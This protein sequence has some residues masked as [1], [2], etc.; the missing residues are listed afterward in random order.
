MA[1]VALLNSARVLAVCNDLQIPQYDYCPCNGEPLD[2][3]LKMLGDLA[4][5]PT[6]PTRNGPLKSTQR[7]YCLESVLVDLLSEESLSPRASYRTIGEQVDGSFAFEGRFFLLEAKWVGDAIPASSIYAFKGK[8]DGK[9]SGTLG[10]MIAMSGF[11]EEAVSALIAGKH[12]SVLLADGDDLRAAVS[13]SG[14]FSEM[15]RVK[16]RAAVDEGAVFAPYRITVDGTR[17]VLASQARQAGQVPQ[18]IRI[19]F[20]VEGR[21]D[22]IAVGRL[23]RQVLDALGV[24]L[25]IET[26]PAQGPENAVRLA[27]S[28]R[29]ATSPRTLVGVVVDADH[30]GS[31]VRQRRF[32]EHPAI[33]GRQIVV[34]AASPGLAEDWLQLSPP[35]RPTRIDA[36]EAAVDAVNVDE[37]RARSASFARFASVLEKHVRGLPEADRRSTRTSS[38]P[39]HKPERYAH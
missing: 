37:L 33:R 12:L 31:V 9:L 10:L 28:L 24:S 15:L 7:G 21:S 17:S 4:A 35:F 39:T 26:F 20:A 22:A 8:V 18:D 25:E 30:E 11:S 6:T 19:Q 13:E 36:V 3:R 5:A 34:I 23:G 27:G 32:G 38:E 14:S 2:K 1:R 29:D 16:V